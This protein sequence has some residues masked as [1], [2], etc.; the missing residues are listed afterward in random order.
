MTAVLRRMIGRWV[1]R[2][3]GRHGYDE[4]VRGHTEML[5][6]VAAA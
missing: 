3:C 4:G 2:N 6:G 1:F 5:L